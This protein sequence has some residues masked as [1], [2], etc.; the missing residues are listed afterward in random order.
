MTRTTRSAGFPA[1]FLMLAR[2]T[3]EV[4][5]AFHYRAPWAPRRDA[6]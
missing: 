3:F 1:R 4:N 6:A 5:V 2:Q